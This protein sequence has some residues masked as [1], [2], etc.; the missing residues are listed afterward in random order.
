MSLLLGPISMNRALHNTI[1]PPLF[2]PNSFKSP[3]NWHKKSWERA[4]EPTRPLRP[5]LFQILDTPLHGPMHA[6]F[7]SHRVPVQTE[8]LTLT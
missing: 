3:L 7:E 6:A 4:P 2:A 5:F 1:R 8:E